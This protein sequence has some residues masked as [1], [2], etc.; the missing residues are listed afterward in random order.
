MSVINKMLKDL[1]QRQEGQDTSPIENH[2]ATPNAGTQLSSNKASST[3]ITLVLII[4][5]VLLAFIGYQMLLNNKGR[6]ADSTNQVAPAL[7]T[8]ASEPTQINNELAEPAQS[9]DPD[10]AAE[11]EQPPAPETE[12]VAE[13]TPD[14]PVQNEE[15][16]EVTTELVVEEEDQTAPQLEVEPQESSTSQT[17]QFVSTATP[18]SQEP[19]RVTEKAAEEPTFVIEKTSTKLTPEERVERLLNKAKSAYEKGYITEAI[20]DLTKVLSISD[21]H[22]EAR[23]LLAGAWYG[24]GEGNRAIA[25]LNDGLQR[26]PLIEE[27]RTTAAKIF[28]KE[29]RLEGAFSYLNVELTGASKEFYTLKGNLARQLKQF[30][31]A[32][33]AYSKL[34]ELEPFVGNWWL[35]LAI[36]QDSQAKSQ[37][38]LASYIKVVETGGVS[39]QSLSFA[40]QRIEK[41]KG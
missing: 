39:A 18:S 16:E 23:T 32:E 30:S 13:T 28:F 14:L 29:N 25:I 21:G 3:A 31:A 12:L 24:R 10:P 41:L 8:T 26:Y 2:A 37:Q 34:T 7:M 22:I 20:E 40:Q 6:V 9:V 15:P 17:E 5:A 36:A 19:V 11:L 35:G 27:W 38:A 4:I 33:L 1:D